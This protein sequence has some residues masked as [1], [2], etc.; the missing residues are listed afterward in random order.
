MSDA[1]T[2]RRVREVLAGRREAYGWI[3]TRHEAR[4]R[5][6]LAAIL[7]EASRVEDA[8]QEVFVTAYRKLDEYRPGT[9]FGLWI[10]AIA[11]NVGLNERRGWIRAQEATKRNRARIET[12]MQPVLDGV[13]DRMQGDVLAELRECIEHLPADARDVI[14]SRYFAGRSCGEIA[15]LRKRSAV[16]VRQALFLARQILHDCLAKKG[17]A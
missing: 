8:A 12:A 1:E 17:L 14:R 3:V 2:D 10:K 6:V 15:A 16:G 7:P 5:A 11:R 13:I 9:E 4:V